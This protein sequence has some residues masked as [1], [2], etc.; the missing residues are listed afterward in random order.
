MKGSI[1]PFMIILW[2]IILILLLMSKFGPF[3]IKEAAQDLFGTLKIIEEEE[4]G[5]ETELVGNTNNIIEI[6]L[7]ESEQSSRGQLV[8]AAYYCWQRI[9]TTQEDKHA[10]AIVGRAAG[11]NDRENVLRSLRIRDPQAADALDTSWNIPDAIT[12]YIGEFYICSQD[13]T[14]SD[15]LSFTYDLNDCGINGRFGAQRSIT[16]SADRATAI[17][18]LAGSLARCWKIAE[19]RDSSLVCDTINPDQ[20]NANI[21]KAHVL[22]ATGEYFPEHII[23]IIDDWWE[24]EDDA[25]FPTTIGR[26]TK[27]FYS[28]AS[29]FET[30][31]ITRNDLCFTFDQENDC[32]T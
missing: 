13:G 28:C 29:D 27:A 5:R 17:K 15:V 7:D 24:P 31:A 9:K 8:D 32:C 18:E 11:S 10:C 4:Y 12:P 20:I 25:E 19:E 2:L 30:F 1:I 21:Q 16:L 26:K 23:D 22:T 14:F 6:N 3:S